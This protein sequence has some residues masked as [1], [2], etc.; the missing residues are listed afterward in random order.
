MLEWLK[1]LSKQL[2]SEPGWGGG[3]GRAPAPRA[4][5]PYQIAAVVLMIEASQ[6]DESVLPEERLA[7][8]SAIREALD[9]DGQKLESLL[10][11]ASES[12]RA[13]TSLYEFTSVLNRDLGQEQKVLLVKM[14]WRIAFADGN[15]DR[16]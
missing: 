15:V 5:H 12:A 7:I 14:L 10:A 16:F 2:A 1:Q 11:A 8:E 13:A 9:L 4:E 3:G 6:A